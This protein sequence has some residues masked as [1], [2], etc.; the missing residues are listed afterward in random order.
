[1]GTHYNRFAG[2]NLDRL[3]ALSDGIF[4][5]AMTL[6]VL[7]LHT[8]AAAAIHDSRGLLLALLELA[9]KLLVYALSFM[10]L[11]IF[12]VGQQ[13]QLNHLARASR[14]LTW[15]H[16]AFLGA[17]TLLPF[18]TALI[19]EFITL[20]AA[21]LIYWLN[22]LALGALLSLAW[23][24]AVRHSLLAADAPDALSAAIQRRILIAQALYAAGAALCVLNTY[25]SLAV[26]VLVQLNYAVAPRLLRR[27]EI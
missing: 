20:R 12:W 16:L 13:T 4:A 7:E 6:L 14:D 1:M 15:L 27:R 24:H 21:L 10:T 22:I 25:W 2:G 8:P 5:I 23:R 3:A 19:G 26:I 11:G 17:V 18:T 9:P